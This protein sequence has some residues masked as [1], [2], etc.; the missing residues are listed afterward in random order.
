M[1]KS[2]RLNEV[3]NP[4]YCVGKARRI[5]RSS[6]LSL[7]RERLAERQFRMIG[8]RSVLSFPQA[9]RLFWNAVGGRRYVTICVEEYV[10]PKPGCRLLDI[11]CGPGNIVPYLRDVEYVGFDM[12]AEYIESARKHYPQATFV[13]GLVSQYTLPNLEYFDVVLALGILHHLDDEEAHQLFEIAFQ[14]LKPGG[15]LVSIDGVFTKDQ[16]PVARYL[17]KRDRGRFV[18]NLDGYVQIA[19]RVFPQVKSTLRHDLLRIPYTHII[20]ECSR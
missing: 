6:E 2:L 12:S 5:Y 3:A 19:S 7:F 15:K 17:L 9:Y 20:M 13:C 8:L 10:K 14:G 11:G 18:R 16:S 4:Y 1:S